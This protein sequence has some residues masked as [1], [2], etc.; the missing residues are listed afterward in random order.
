MS[1]QTPFI[2]HSE[3]TDEIYIIVGREKYCVTEQVLKAVQQTGRAEPVRRGRWI[4]VND[5]VYSC[6]V[7]GME[8]IIAG[9]PKD[10]NAN[11]CINCGAKMNGVEE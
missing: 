5:D 9:D 10:E 3:I 4:K 2:A 7:C 6:S 11:Y 8:I 1:K